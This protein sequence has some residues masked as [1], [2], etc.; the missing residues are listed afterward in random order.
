MRILLAVDGS[1]PAERAIDLVRSASWPDGTEIRVLS[2][3]P[4]YVELAMGS[5]AGPPMAISP[6]MV[7]RILAA[8]HTEAE[9]VAKPATASLRAAGRSVHPSVIEGRPATA[10]IAQA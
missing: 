10:I 7:D 4:P 5:A 1:D 6:D 3:V 2:V 8:A 9:R